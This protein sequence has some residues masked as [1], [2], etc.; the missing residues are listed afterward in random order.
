MD[1]IKILEKIL[2][3]IGGKSMDKEQINIILTLINV[4]SVHGADV[5]KRAISNM[6]KENITAKDIEELKIS[7][8]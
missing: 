8:Q 1:F 7:K 6:N 2:G 4:V 5:V 3:R